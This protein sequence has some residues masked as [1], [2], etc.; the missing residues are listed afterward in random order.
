MACS[1]DTII[2]SRGYHVY[3]ETSWSNAKVSDEVKVETETNPKSIA[4]DPYSCAI[5][6]KH[7]YFLGWKT[8]GH[9]P[10]ELSRYVQEG[11][12]VNGKLNSLKYKASPIPSGGLEVPLSLK[13]KCDEKWVLDAMEEFVDN[14]YSCDFAGNLVNDEDEDDESVDFDTVVIE[15]GEKFK[16]ASS[17]DKHEGEG[18]SDETEMDLSGE[19]PVVVSDSDSE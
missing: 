2:A 3:K 5:K 17:D 18:D 10:L 1:F 16:D 12:K 7:D 19:I 4:S 9:I 11:G 13:F 15:E 14:F 8:V 6:T